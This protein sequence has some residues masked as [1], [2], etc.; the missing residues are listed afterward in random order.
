MFEGQVLEPGWRFGHRHPRR[1]L[2]MSPPVPSQPAVGTFH[3]TA[4]FWRVSARGARMKA[5]LAVAHRILTI[6]WHI[7]AEG[8][9]YQEVGANYYEVDF[10]AQHHPSINYL[11]FDRIRVPGNSIQGS[12][13]LP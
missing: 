5:G 4:L 13:L 10:T 12:P 7:I 9:T 2:L 8:K 3:I 1:L 6:I 11:H